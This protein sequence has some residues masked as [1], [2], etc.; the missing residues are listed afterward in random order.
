MEKKN[1]ARAPRER[2]RENDAREIERNEEN[3]LR[4]RAEIGLDESAH[5][6]SPGLNLIKQT[7]PISGSSQFL[8]VCVCVCNDLSAC[9]SYAVFINI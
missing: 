5:G 1:K 8:R 9:V 7:L 3:M 4:E 2:E 6:E